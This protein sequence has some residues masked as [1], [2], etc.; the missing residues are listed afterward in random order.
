LLKN[1]GIVRILWDFYSYGVG[2]E[3]DRDLGFEVDR[4]LGSEGQ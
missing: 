2:V 1:T 4:D 3:G